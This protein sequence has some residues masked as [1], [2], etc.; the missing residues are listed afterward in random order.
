[1]FLPL[2]PGLRLL[3]QQNTVKVILG[4]FPDPDI[5]K[6]GSNLN[7][8]DVLHWF[9]LNSVCKCFTLDIK[10]KKILVYNDLFIV[11]LFDYNIKFKLA[12]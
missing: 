4:Q 11:Y 6:L 12:L 7:S 5:K 1:M 2:E 8:A 9:L 3:H 10:S